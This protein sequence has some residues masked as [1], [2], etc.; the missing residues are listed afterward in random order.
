MAIGDAAVAA[1]MALVNAATT[2]ANLIA[3]EINRTRDY[4]ATERTQRMVADDGK[5]D[6]PTDGGLMARREPG[7]VHNIGFYT[8]VASALYFRPDA[9]TATYDRKVITQAEFDAL[10]ARVTA[11]ET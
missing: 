10:A 11:L 6:K 5:V 8:D 3:E 1:G 7:S 2:L 9:T 4:I